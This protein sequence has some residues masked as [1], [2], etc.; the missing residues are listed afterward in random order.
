MTGFRLQPLGQ[1][2]EPEPGNPL[3]VEGVLNPESAFCSDRCGNST[4]RVGTKR[5]RPIKSGGRHR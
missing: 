4:G 3:E 2:M 5:A 1:V